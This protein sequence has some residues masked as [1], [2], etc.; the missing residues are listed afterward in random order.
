MKTT[1]RQNLVVER[2]EQLYHTHPSLWGQAPGRVDLMGSHT[3]YNMGHVMTMSIDRNTWV[4][5][6]SRNDR[7]VRIYSINMASGGQFDL[8]DIQRDPSLAWTNYVRGVA[9]V[10]QDEGHGLTGLDGVIH[11]SIPFGSGLSSSAAIEMATAVIFRELDGMTIDPV[12]MALM[13]QRAENEFV[14]V[15]CG[16]LDQYS[17][18]MGESGKALLLDCRNLTSRTMVVPDHLRLVI[19]DTRATRELSGSEYSERRAQCEQGVAIL[20]KFYPA[21]TALRDVDLEQFRAHELDLPRI[22]ARRCRFV[23]EE[24]QRVLDLA[25]ILKRGDEEALAKIAHDSYMGARD[26]YEIGAP[27]MEA[28]MHS[29]QAGPGVIAARQAGAGFG[30]CMVAFVHSP[31]V[32]SFCAFVR[33][34]YRH[35][36]GIRPEIY[37][38]KAAP[39]AG[40]L[41]MPDP[42]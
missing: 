13:G 12:T 30:G 35:R 23:I 5:A 18:A 38:V 19:C 27:A 40:L 21:V 28:M 31:A 16:I 9:K 33:E 26:L 7:L 11:S 20:K 4:A 36:T 39:G 17:S 8:D 37:P 25:D 14:G 2:F 15:N 10:F 3:D 34:D 29:M 32:E 42:I 22:V 6:R 41:T 24:N 1:Q